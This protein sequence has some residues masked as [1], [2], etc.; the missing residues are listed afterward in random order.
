MS[1]PKLKDK[2]RNMSSNAQLIKEL[3]RKT[4][5][6]MKDCVKALKASDNDLQK[7]V[8]WLRLNG[9]YSAKKKA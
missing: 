1:E 2:M 6:G 5:A 8:E 3:R 7:A 4:D 9:V